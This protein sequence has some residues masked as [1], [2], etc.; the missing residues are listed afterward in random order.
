MLCVCFAPGPSTTQAVAQKWAVPPFRFPS[1]STPAHLSSDS[2]ATLVTERS[3]LLALAKLLSGS[4]PD[5]LGWQAREPRLPPARRAPSPGT[6]HWPQT[7][8]TVAPLLPLSKD[9][10]GTSARLI[11]VPTRLCKTSRHRAS[12]EMAPSHDLHMLPQ[13]YGCRRFRWQ[14]ALRSMPVLHS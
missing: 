9:A 11:V 4:A 8:S 5:A 2:V 14:L 3:Q 12:S 6:D 10:R 7:S 1:P 13:Q